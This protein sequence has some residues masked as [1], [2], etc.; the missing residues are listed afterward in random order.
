MIKQL[1]ATLYILKRD[2]KPLIAI[3]VQLILTIYMI[4]DMRYADIIERGSLTTVIQAFKSF[5]CCVLFTLPVSSLIFVSMTINRDISSGSRR[6]R[7][8]VGISRGSILAADFVT[9]AVFNLVCFLIHVLAMVL[10]FKISA[11]WFGFTWA[12]IRNFLPFCLLWIL[13]W[14]AFLTM[15]MNVFDN[16][17]ARISTG[18]IFAIANIFLAKTFTDTNGIMR[19]KGF[20]RTVLLFISERV[21]FRFMLVSLS[22]VDVQKAAEATLTITVLCLITGYI[23]IKRKNVR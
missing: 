11:P 15:V 19:L 4:V 5:N 21:P 6:N 20:K 7:I 1:R 16:E 22:G 8:T 12:R 18:L 23:A 9:I 2:P 14:T 10:L 13:A 3:L 17:V